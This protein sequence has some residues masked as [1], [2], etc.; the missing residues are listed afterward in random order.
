[1]PMSLLP[2]DFLPHRWP[3]QAEGAMHHLAPYLDSSRKATSGTVPMADGDDCN[4]ICGLRVEP[5]GLV[6][7]ME[8]ARGEPIT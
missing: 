5:R 3:H 4:R 1:M 7:K 8:S 2:L 6:A